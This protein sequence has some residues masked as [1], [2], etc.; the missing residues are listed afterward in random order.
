[1]VDKTRCSWD[2]RYGLEGHMKGRID[3][4]FGHLTGMKEQWARRHEILQLEDLVQ[5]WEASWQEKGRDMED[6]VPLKIIHFSP[7][8][9]DSVRWALLEDSSFAAPLT[10]CHSWQAVLL[11]HRRLKLT[12]KQNPFSITA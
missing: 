6:Q 5:A 9:K 7:P 4:L 10:A 1:M 11:D 2:V 8:P 3:S 12:G